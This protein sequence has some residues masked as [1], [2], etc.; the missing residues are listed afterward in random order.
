MEHCR[1]KL[2]TVWGKGGQIAR[3]QE[4]KGQSLA[5]PRGKR[6]ARAAFGSLAGKQLGKRMAPLPRFG[7]DRPRRRAQL[8]CRTPLVI[9]F[10]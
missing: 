2:C 5:F 10:V 1:E 6:A 8:F 7:R 4:S 3:S 9:S